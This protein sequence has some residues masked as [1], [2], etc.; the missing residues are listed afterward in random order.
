M[1]TK[2]GVVSDTHS[3]LDPRIA[4]II[5]ECDIAIHAG[6]ICGVEVI[7]AMKPKSGEI[8]AVTGNNDPYCHFSDTVLPESLDFEIAGET[9]AVEHGHKHGVSQPS[10]ESLRKSHP[11]AKMVIYGHTHKQV[12]DKEAMPWVINPGAAGKTRTHGGPSCLVIHCS[13]SQEWDIVVHR[14]RDYDD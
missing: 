14:F 6:D 9:I 13:K 10:H 3:F 7:E 1:I 2:V 8:F 12:I 11:N 4:E 5:L